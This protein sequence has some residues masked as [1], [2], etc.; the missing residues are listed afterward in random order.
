MLGRAGRLL[1]NA[2]APPL[3]IA[4]CG[5]SGGSEGPIDPSSITLTLDRSSISVTAEER[6]S[7]MPVES[8][9][10]RLSRVP[11]EGFVIS[12]NG[13]DNGVL[14]GDILDTGETT[15]AIQLRFRSSEFMD[16]GV[17]SDSVT[18]SVCLD[19]PCTRHLSGSPKTI[20]TQYT[21][22]PVKVTDSTESR[23]T[24][25]L[26]YIGAA[27]LAWD[28]NSSRL[29]MVTESDSTK[30]PNSLVSLDP[31]SGTFSQLLSLPFI[32]KKMAISGSGSY[33]YVE[34]RFDGYT[35]R[36][37]L[38][39]VTLD[40]QISRI[41]DELSLSASE[42]APL[43]E[44]PLS[45]AVALESG[46]TPFRIRIVDDQTPRPNSISVPTPTP[47]HLCSISPTVLWGSGHGFFAY[48]VD[49]NGISQTTYGASTNPIGDVLCGSDLAHTTLVLA[50][51]PSDGTIARDYVPQ[52]FRAL[53]AVIDVE[54]DRYFLLVSSPTN[55]L[56]LRSFEASTGAVLETVLIYGLTADD[57][58]RIVRWGADGLAVLSI[59]NQVL[60]VRGTFVAG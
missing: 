46:N 47:D 58:D 45:Y 35:N 2:I 43:P 32:P 24:G 41:S 31:M 34:P 21:V 48:S 36:Y 59:A 26:F 12:A 13:S 4:G 38:P 33:L 30:F 18:V 19:D 52:G 51:D 25:R 15:F 50:V 1:A 29:L 49:E 55:Q 40:A 9:N 39:T 53:G 60:V 42:I 56:E 22:T 8:I 3:F 7:T 54:L 27:D 6:S 16:A 11:D 17:Y 37:T 14:N 20:T 5:G 57:V 28:A 10:F 23:L 44:A